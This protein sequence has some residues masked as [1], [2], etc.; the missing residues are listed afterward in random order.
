MLRI[1]LADD[2][3]MFRSGLR[4]IL[5][6]EF[7]GAAFGEAATLPTLRA[8]LERDAWDV[9][10]L[11]VSMAGENSLNSLPSI[12][13]ARPKLPV[14]VLSMYGERQFVIRA[15]RA[16]ASAYVTKERAPEELLRAV[17]SVLA[18]RRYVGNE[19]AEQLADHLAGA[20]AGNPHESLSPRELE[21]F[22]ML[23]SAR[24]VSE[25]AA[26]LELSVKTVS[27]HR[28]R[29]LEKMALRS[30]AELMQYAVRHG[31]VN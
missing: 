7:P 8:L 30:N 14:V 12:K 27:T 1:L 21:I 22:L 6:P 31:L 9:L 23:A 28:S 29:I 2:H 18:G 19:L 20:D 15:L 24:S 3:A 10:I 4:R 17:R 5:E 25:I 26:Q 13:E 11:D 16:G